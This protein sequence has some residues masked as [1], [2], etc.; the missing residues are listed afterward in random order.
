MVFDSLFQTRSQDLH[1]YLQMYPPPP[2]IGKVGWP[3]RLVM[4]S[5]IAR[6]PVHVEDEP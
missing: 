5:E 2:P 4:V 1:I 6:L 3:E